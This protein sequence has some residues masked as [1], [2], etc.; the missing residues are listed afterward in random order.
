MAV[1]PRAHLAKDGKTVTW[2]VRFRV[3]G[4]DS[5][6]TTKTFGTEEGARSF[7]GL[8]ATL[9]PTRAV[10]I[11]KKRT[12][13]ATKEGMPTVA[14]W[15]TRH[16]EKLTGVGGSTLA[17][18]RGHVRNDLGDLAPLPIDAVTSDDIAD[19]VNAA[20]KE[21]VRG[22]KPISGKTIANRHSFL[23]GAFKRAVRAGLIASNP[24]EG[25]RLPRTEREPMVFLTHEEYLVFLGCF[26]P[27]WQPL[28]TTLFST[29]IRWGEATALRVGDV[30]LDRKVLAVER[31]WKRDGTVG[32]PKSKKSRRTVA[33][34]P[35]V[36]DVLTPLVEDRPGHAYVFTNNAGEHV[37]HRTFSKEAWAPAV[38]LANGEPAQGKKGGRVAVRHDS[39]GAEIKPLKT[40]LGKRPRIHD[41]RHSNAS[42]LLGAGVPINYV[43]AHLGHESITT[44]VD[45]YGHVMPAAQV[46]IRSAI[47]GALAAAHP[48]IEA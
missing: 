35:E 12:G 42:W 3:G 4:R 17:T 29:G 11:L 45:R 13:A 8:L 38:R 16:I 10:E 6:E 40:A 7:A 28:V 19:W 36:V 9:G 47:S 2:S 24:C 34:A 46:A 33:L 39:T 26:I 20:A 32:A 30:D 5:K 44:T 25:T 14:Q 48:Q 1:T 22:G 43:Q 37:K 27:R 15:C 21:K 41:A 18:Y 23:S 31:A